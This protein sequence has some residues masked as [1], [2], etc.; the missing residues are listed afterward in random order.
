M[1]PKREALGRKGV[2]KARSAAPSHAVPE[3]RAQAAGSRDPR[4]LGHGS[5]APR[6]RG[7]CRA[8]KARGMR[9]AVKARGMDSGVRAAAM[10]NEVRVRAMGSEARDKVM[11]NVAP[12]VRMDSAIKAVDMGSGQAAEH[13]R[14]ARRAQVVGNGAASNKAAALMDK[15]K[16]R[17]MAAV[18]ED[19]ASNPDKAADM[20][21]DARNAHVRKGSRAAVTGH[22]SMVQD[23]ALG[24]ARRVN[25]LFILRTFRSAHPGSANTSHAPAATK[26][27]LHAARAAHRRTIISGTGNF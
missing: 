26:A 23:R 7:M 21:R 18:R 11:N 16:A 12:R 14:N 13:D 2:E 5:S 24:R 25:R 27:Q 1:A 8:V 10:G 19:M 3:H 6:D 4:A 9:R 22:A 15:D 17:V 20:A